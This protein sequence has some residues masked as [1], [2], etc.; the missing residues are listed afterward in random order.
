MHINIHRLLNHTNLTVVLDLVIVFQALWMSN[1]PPLI[2][3]SGLILSTIIKLRVCQ[4]SIKGCFFKNS[5]SVMEKGCWRTSFLIVVINKIT[6]APS[7]IEKTALI[8]F[9]WKLSFVLSLWLPPIASSC[10]LGKGHRSVPKTLLI[11]W[12]RSSVGCRS[13]AKQY[14]MNHHHPAR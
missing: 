3:Q 1:S 9:S 6:T 7:W 4:S 12:N 2:F 8:E 11:R 5:S 10:F 13:G 14:N